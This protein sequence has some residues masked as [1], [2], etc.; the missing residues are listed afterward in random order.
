[1]NRGQQ[2]SSKICNIVE[3]PLYITYFPKS[4]SFISSRHKNVLSQ[5]KNF[6]EAVK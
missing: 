2:S 4:S 5:Q 1:M 6:R 3:T